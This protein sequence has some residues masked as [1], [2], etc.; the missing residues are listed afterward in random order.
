MKTI[1]VTGGSGFVAGWIIRE[2]LTHDYKVR[3][4]LRDTSKAEEI[5]QGIMLLQPTT[6]SK[7]LS[8]FKADLTNDNGWDEGMKGADGVIH[9]ASPLGH[10]T[11]SVEEMV[12]VAKGGTLTVLKAAKDN[13]IKRIIMTSSEA[14][15]TPSIS[16]GEKTIDESFWSD[17]KNPELDAYRISKI[18]AERAAWQYA[19]DNQLQ[20]TTILPGAVFG[21]ILSPDHLSSDEILLKLLNGERMIPKV[22]MEIS[23]VRDLATLHRL[24]LE[25]DVAIGHRFLAADQKLTMAEIAQ[26]YQKQYPRLQLK[27]TYLPNWV[28]VLASKFSPSLRPLVPMLKR[29][30]SHTTQ[31][32]QKLLGWKQRPVQ[33]T[34]TDAADLLIFNKLVKN[35]PEKTYR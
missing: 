28:T 26:I 5:G 14:A 16:V 20:L 2:L 19:K 18:E 34:I 22:P 30:Y 4:S 33:K 11:E 10:G 31:S 32:T 13:H 7:N 15:S 27:F 1:V 24:A 29:K 23:D 17:I 21:P 9:V 3:A 35:I 6:L 25:K 8:F 12:K